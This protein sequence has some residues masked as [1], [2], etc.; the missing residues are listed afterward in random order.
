MR[1]L[2]FDAGYTLIN[3]DRVWE[4]RCTEQAETEEAKRLGLSA[5]DLYREIGLASAARKT[6]FRSVAAKFGFKEIAPYRHELETLYDDASRVLAKLAGRYK[7]G[8]IANQTDGFQK[9]LE[10]FG[11]LSYFTYIASSWDVGA[12]KPDPRIFEYALALADC[13]PR[14]TVMI[15]DRLDNDVAPAKKL[16]MKT[17]WIR[18]GFGRLQE[19]LGEEDT[20]DFAIDSLPELLTLF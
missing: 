8:I 7:L 6:Q 5:A 13:P 18:Q 14:E 19:P 10:D 3:E 17:V 20:P 12:M 15:G 1:V 11:I 2:F 16:G 4:R 9:R